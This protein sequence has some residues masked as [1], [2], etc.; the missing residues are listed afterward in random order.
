MS[1]FTQ[2]AEAFTLWQEAAS[3]LA[4]VAR[5]NLAWTRAS[6]LDTVGRA[7]SVEDVTGAR[8]ETKIRSQSSDYNEVTFLNVF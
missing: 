7:S 8:L 6:S 2:A 3:S 5:A 4:V 1:S